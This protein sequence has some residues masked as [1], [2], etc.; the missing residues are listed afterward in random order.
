M[1]LFIPS[2]LAVILATVIIMFVLPRF[3]PVVLGV[4]ALVLLV[5]A[6]W[7]H[8]TFFRLEYAQSTWQMPLLQYGPYVLMGGLVLF[9]LFFIVNFI[10][11]GSAASAA[12]LQSMNAALERVTNQVPTVAAATNAVKV[13][14]NNAMKAVGLGN[15]AAPNARAA[16][17]AR[18]NQ[19][20]FSQV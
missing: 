9:L 7:Q 1:E 17:A 11:V 5:L 12:P 8:Y 4:C 10:G 16:N 19:V 2:I 14:A 18:Q 6:A 20:P 3:S 15:A 13:A